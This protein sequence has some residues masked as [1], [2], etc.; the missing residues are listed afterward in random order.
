[1]IRPLREKK[2]VTADYVFEGE[3]DFRRIHFNEA[4]EVSIIIILI[5]R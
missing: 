1:M 5:D 3:I 2:T 4:G